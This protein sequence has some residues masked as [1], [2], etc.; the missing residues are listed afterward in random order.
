[1]DEQPAHIEYNI[2]SSGFDN[3]L[4]S[5]QKK[6]NVFGLSLHCPNPTPY[7][8]IGVARILPGGYTFFSKKVDDLFLVLAPQN[9]V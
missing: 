2:S 5:M 9:S 4:Y 7:V 8:T 1:L 6:G 3:K